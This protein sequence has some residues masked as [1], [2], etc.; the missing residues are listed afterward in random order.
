MYDSEKAYF[1]VEE[2]F[3]NDLAEEIN[4]HNVPERIF[5]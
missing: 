4:E 1:V 3:T 5:V 2:K